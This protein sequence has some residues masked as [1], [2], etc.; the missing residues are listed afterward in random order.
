VPVINSNLTTTVVLTTTPAATKTSTKHNYPV[1]VIL[2]NV[3]IKT[4]IKGTA[5]NWK[6][7]FLEKVSGLMS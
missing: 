2:Q 5:V 3:Y 1:L 6:H 4:C 7:M